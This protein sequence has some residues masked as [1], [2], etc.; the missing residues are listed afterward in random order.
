MSYAGVS[1]RW[2]HRLPPVRNQEGPLRLLE[3]QGTVE[4]VGACFPSLHSNVQA[5]TRPNGEK[6]GPGKR[7]LRKGNRHGPNR[8]LNGADLVGGRQGRTVRDLQ[9]D[10]QGRA[11]RQG[12]AGIRRIGGVTMRRHQGRGP[13]GALSRSGAWHSLC[14]RR[15]KEQREESNQ[16]AE[17]SNPEAASNLRNDGKI[18]HGLGGWFGSGASGGQP[19]RRTGRPPPQFYRRDQARTSYAG[20]KRRADRGAVRPSERRSSGINARLCPWWNE[21]AP[22]GGK[23]NL[24]S[25][26]PVYI[27][28]F[29]RR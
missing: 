28:E 15:M 25:H 3:I 19:R 2:G 26:P 7:Q 6:R 8:G 5:R 11:I 27:F 18:N 17:E 1:L 10:S 20:L 16:E 22:M 14:G 21:T 13:L 24:P 4:A 12:A 9:R 23:T 29:I